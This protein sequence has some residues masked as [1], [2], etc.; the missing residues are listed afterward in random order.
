MVD[1]NS[2]EEKAKYDFGKYRK[3][4]NIFILNNFVLFK[5]NKIENISWIY[6]HAFP[7]PWATTKFHWSLDQAMF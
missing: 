3:V 5:Q 7:R 2:T 1:I 4:C 6:I